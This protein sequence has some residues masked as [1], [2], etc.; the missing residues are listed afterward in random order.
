MRVDVDLVTKV[1]NTY[2]AARVI[3]TYDI[4]KVDEQHVRIQAD[5]PLEG[6]DWNVGCIIGA[7]GSGKSTIARNLWP[8]AYTTN[9]SHEWNADCLLDDFP[10]ALTPDEVIG[11]LTSVGFSSAPAWLRPHRVLSVGQGFRAD[12]ARGLALAGGNG[13]V[14]FDEFT[15]TV[16]RVVAKA[17]SAAVSKHARRNGSKFVAVS[18]H[19]DIA[20]WLG[21]DWMY[22]TDSHQFTGRRLHRPSIGLEI[23][24][25]SRQAWSLFRD[26]HYLSG[27]LATASRVFL[28]YVTL[29]EGEERLAA[30]LALLPVAGHK[31]WWRSHRT[32]VLPDMQG[33]GIGNRFQEEIAEQLWVKEH[34]RFRVV[35]SAPGM[36]HYCRKRPEKWRLAMAPGM[37]PLPGKTTGL[38]K[39]KGPKTSSGRLTTTWVYLPTSLRK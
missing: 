21:A 38:G 28:G 13:L 26:H 15:S 35:T 16:D 12:L 6:M 9:G 25:G 34:K 36:V 37:K 4:P 31:G 24:E 14:V 7:S 27:D 5:I 18:C 1:P 20:P 33:L 10:E 17:V 29:D 2:R 22:D 39:G 32:V 19:K 8:D 11:F 3:G 23:R 30:F